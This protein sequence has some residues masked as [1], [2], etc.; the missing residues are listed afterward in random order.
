ML[1]TSCRYKKIPTVDVQMYIY[2]IQTGELCCKDAVCRNSFWRMK[3]AE[4]QGGSWSEFRLAN[5]NCRTILQACRKSLFRLTNA[6]CRKARIHFL[7]ILVGDCKLQNNICKDAVFR[8]SVWQMHS[9]EQYCKDAV[10]QNSDIRTVN[11][12]KKCML[13]YG[14]DWAKKKDENKSVYTPCRT[15][16]AFN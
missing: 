15:P 8:N 9:K 10:Y 5:A 7:E 1:A 12:A 3:I 2:Q 4:K 16:V 14:W 6:N 13:I 11:L